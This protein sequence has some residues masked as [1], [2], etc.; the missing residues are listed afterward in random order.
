MQINTIFSQI[1]TLFNNSNKPNSQIRGVI[2]VSALA[3]ITSIGILVYRSS[4]LSIS[5]PKVDEV[6]ALPTQEEI[7]EIRDSA[8]LTEKTCLSHEDLSTE[9]AILQTKMTYHAD[10]VHYINNAKGLKKHHAMAALLTILG[11]KPA[12][13]LSTEEGAELLPLLK[14]ITKE[15]SNLLLKEFNTDFFGL[16]RANFCLANESPLEIFNPKHF[17]KPLEDKAATLLDTTIDC[18]IYLKNPT[19]EQRLSYL[20]GYGPSWE[21]FKVHGASPFDSNSDHSAFSDAH[22]T[23]LG[24]VFSKNNPKET[25]LYIHQQQA[26]LALDRRLKKEKPFSFNNNCVVAQIIN[27]TGMGHIYDGISARSEYSQKSL[28]LQKWLLEKYFPNS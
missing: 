10:F 2:I 3:A 9:K 4:S 23:E 5:S 21:A 7:Q 19:K 22:Y 15:D 14:R 26:S 25:G 28:S 20:L 1:G 27:K 17:L 13:V 12:T 18:L 24:K 6:R 16:T 11:I 8:S